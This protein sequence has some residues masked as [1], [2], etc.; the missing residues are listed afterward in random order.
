MTVHIAPATA[1]TE[2][3]VAYIELKKFCIV[4]SMSHIAPETIHKE[5]SI[6]NIEAAAAHTQ[7]A[8][9]HT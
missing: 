8:T 7:D 9:A 1:P 5:V 2:N 6:V 3:A 4:P